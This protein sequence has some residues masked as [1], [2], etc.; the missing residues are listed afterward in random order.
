MGAGKEDQMAE[1]AFEFDFEGCV[2]FADKIFKAKG[3]YKNGNAEGISG[4]G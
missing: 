1:V 2:H 3:Q 4:I